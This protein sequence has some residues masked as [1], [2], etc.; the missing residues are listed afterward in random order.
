M[1]RAN[2]TYMDVWTLK[3]EKIVQ[4][5]AKLFFKIWNN[6]FCETWA[7]RLMCQFQNKVTSIR[8]NVFWRKRYFMIFILFNILTFRLRTIKLHAQIIWGWRNWDTTKSCQIKLLVIIYT[9]LFR[10]LEVLWLKL[11]N[12][13]MSDVYKPQHSSE[14]ST[15]KWRFQLH[16][17]LQLTQITMIVYFKDVV[18]YGSW[19]SFKGFGLTLCLTTHC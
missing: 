12:Q 13:D 2:S 17:K 16:Q 5:M 1:G 11:W 9:V 4:E 3:L 19:V 10:H 18:A 14:L 8:T 6:K 15:L 7:K